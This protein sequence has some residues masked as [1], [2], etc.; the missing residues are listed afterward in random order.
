LRQN[1]EV[2]PYGRFAD[3]DAREHD[4]VARGDV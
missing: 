2:G 4:L 3:A 1:I